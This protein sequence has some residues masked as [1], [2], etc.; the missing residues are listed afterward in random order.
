M[1]PEPRATARPK[2]EQVLELPL[3]KMP[4]TCCLDVDR[5]E[6]CSRLMFRGVAFNAPL[7]ARSEAA[8]QQAALPLRRPALQQPPGVG[9]VSRRK[10]VPVVPLP[11]SVNMANAPPA[12][13]RLE[14]LL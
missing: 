8:K 2:L 14:G 5:L 11:D 1:A 12:R 9:L 6:T 7:T 13:A 4:L 10:R 3:S